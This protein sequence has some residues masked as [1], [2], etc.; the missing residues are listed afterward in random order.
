MSSLQF[1]L[2]K[3]DETRNYHLE[4]T[5]SNKLMSGNYKMAYKYLSYV[6]HFLILASSVIGSVSISSFTT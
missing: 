4:E 1:K 6:E 3:L 5:K 2:K